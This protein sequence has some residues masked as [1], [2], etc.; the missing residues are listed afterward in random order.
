MKNK[1]TIIIGITG[2]IGSGKT[3]AAKYFE[4]LGFPIY[5]SD[6]RAKNIQ[7]NHPEV[8]QEIKNIFGDEA[9][10]ADG[11]NRTYI[12]SQTF[13][14]KEKLMQ[15]NAVVHPAV[16]EDF[17]TW[18]NQQDAKFVMKE[19]AILIESGSYKDCDI[20]ISVVA[21]K[22]IRIQRTIERDQ[23]TR[24]EILKRIENQLSDEERKDYSDFIIDNS[25]DLAYLYNQIEIIV[26]K[27]KNNTNFD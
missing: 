5:N 21:D 12:A 24:E 17:K 10:T 9:Y 16:F 1:K 27:I 19:A 25:Q 23:L 2:G 3:T 4:K 18:I 6:V 7:N 8:I 22:E 20:I 14:N 13:N 11:M 15:L 26:D